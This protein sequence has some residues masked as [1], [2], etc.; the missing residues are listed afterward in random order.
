MKSS[1]AVISLKV[2]V[3]LSL[4]GQEKLK[5]GHLVIR[6][7]KSIAFSISSEAALI[8]QAHLKKKPASG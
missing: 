6:A 7:Q 3:T 1:L 8:I 4:D 5:D 2:L